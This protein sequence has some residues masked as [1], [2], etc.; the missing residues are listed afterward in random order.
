[1]QACALKKKLHDNYLVQIILRTPKLKL[2]DPQGF[3]TSVLEPL[4]Y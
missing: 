2:A 4:P 1:M 3:L